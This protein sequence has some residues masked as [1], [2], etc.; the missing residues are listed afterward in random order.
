MLCA[1]CKTP[2]PASATK[3]PACG[4]ATPVDLDTTR[5]VADETVAFSQ[6]ADAAFT[7]VADAAFT[8]LTDQTALSTGQGRDW[9][10]AFTTS[11]AV[12]YQGV[13]LSTGTIL[14]GRYEIL[15]TL[16][17][18]G[19]GAVFKARDREVDRIVALKVIRPE[20]A[21]SDDILKRFRQELVLARKI[22][23]RNVVRIFDLGIAD[24]LRFISMEY[25]DGRELAHILHEKGTL[26]PK[27]AAEIMLQVCRG[28][29]VA[30]AEGVIH[31]DLKPQNIMVD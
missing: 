22:T 18:G 8:Q 28:L 31:R 7:Q 27:D 20:L 13:S 6:G 14:G 21:G 3:C 17:E 23:H 15:Q 12:A 1:S 5:V 11:D 10:K 29:A 2:V 4:T 16:G 25:I 19:M 30:H 24:G 9:S 26:A